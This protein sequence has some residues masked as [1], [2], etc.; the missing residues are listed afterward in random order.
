MSDEKP[1][2]RTALQIF[3]EYEAPLSTKVRMAVVNTV[4]KIRTRKNCCGNLGE[5]G[6]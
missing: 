6:C 2:A 5:P 3:R 1:S 4:T